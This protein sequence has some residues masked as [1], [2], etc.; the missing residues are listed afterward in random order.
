MIADFSERTAQI[1][2]QHE[3]VF[4][5][6]AGFADAIR[7]ARAANES[8]KPT[9]TFTFHLNPNLE[10]M[11]ADPSTAFINLLAETGGWLGFIEHSVAYRI[12][13]FLDDV[14]TGIEGARPYR[15]VNAARCLVELCALLHH[16]SKVIAG[17][18]SNLSALPR[19]DIV[20]TVSGIVSTLDA[21]SHFAQVT[22]FNWSA[23][24]RG[25]MD[26]FFAE[27]SK[28]DARVE[29]KTILSYIDKLPGEEKRAARFFY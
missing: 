21:A 17:A 16:H 27:W 22:R 13:Q 24:V 23:L 11:G 28:V 25:Q 12:A 18:A 10:S 19:D 29:A 20:R 8:V 26:E 2:A 4:P 9:H 5:G 3:K 14:V 6:T 7:K 15:V 1:I